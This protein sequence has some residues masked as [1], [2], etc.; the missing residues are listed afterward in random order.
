MRTIVP[1]IIIKVK[2]RPGEWFDLM[3]TL[4]FASFLEFRRGDIICEAGGN[5]VIS[6]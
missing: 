4:V 3:Q 6:E 1:A 5:G 2:V